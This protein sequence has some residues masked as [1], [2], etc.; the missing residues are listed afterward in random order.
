VAIVDFIVD[1]P[2]AD[3]AST[4]GSAQVLMETL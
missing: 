1:R 4:I 3:D 2:Q